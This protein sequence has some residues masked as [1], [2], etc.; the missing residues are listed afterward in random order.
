MIK[1]DAL[2]YQYYGE[3]IPEVL[4][5]LEAD[6]K[7]LQNHAEDPNYSEAMTAFR[8]RRGELGFGPEADP[9]YRNAGYQKQKE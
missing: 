9:D 5:D 1:K 8:I 4:F 6:P 7:E 2:K 3:D